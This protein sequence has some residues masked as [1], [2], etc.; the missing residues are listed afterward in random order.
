MTRLNSPGLR[1]S[2]TDSPLHKVPEHDC[3]PKDRGTVFRTAEVD[4]R[5]CRWQPIK[6]NDDDWPKKVA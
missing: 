6:E 5:T 4:Q 1:Y 2:P 3:K